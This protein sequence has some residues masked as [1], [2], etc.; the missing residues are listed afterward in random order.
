MTF[1]TMSPVVL[2]TPTVIVVVLLSW[3]SGFPWMRMRCCRNRTATEIS[4][5]A[6]SIAAAIRLMPLLGDS[7]GHGFPS[8]IGVR[9]FVS[10]Q[11]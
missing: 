5:A 9:K 3:C 7:D 2:R 11:L 4:V 6:A 1:L 8:L 10:L